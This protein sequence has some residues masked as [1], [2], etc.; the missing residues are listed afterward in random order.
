MPLQNLVSRNIFSNQINVTLRFVWAIR[1]ICLLYIYIY[2]GIDKVH[3][4]PETNKKIYETSHK[5]NRKN[6]SNTK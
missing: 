2:D 5:Q 1:L 3:H 4:H 6:K